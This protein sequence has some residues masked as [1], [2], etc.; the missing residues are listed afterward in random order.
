MEI[1]PIVASLKKHRIPTLLIV[2]QIALACA[3][4]CN[5]VFMIGG[6]VRQMR[7]ANAI[8]E[9][10]LVSV[11]LQGTD[12]K[13]IASDT[14]RNLAALRSIAGVQAV[15][16]VHTLPLTN[17]NWGWSFGITPD[18]SVTDQKN[19]N[20]TL[21]FVGQGSQRALGLRLLEGRYFSD[22]EYVDNAIAGGALPNT[23]LVVITQALGKQLWPGQSALGKTLYSKPNYYTVV[24]VVADVLRPRL[25]SDNRKSYYS[26]FFPV[27]ADDV[28]R[29]YVLRGAPADRDRILREAIDALQ[30]ANPQAVVKGVTFQAIRDKYYADT[31]SMVWILVLV[32]AVMLAVT[33]F[34][35]V[36]LTSFWV[37]Q[38]RRQI[39]IRRAVG[40]TR[41][42]ILRYFRTEN[43]LL[44]SAGVVL[45]MIMA[46]GVNL[47]LMKQ[48]ELERMPWY[49]LPAGALALWLIG[50]LAVS[51]PA[52]RA[53]AVPP[54][55]ATQPA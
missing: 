54:V 45:G 20:V 33:A 31:N 41:A 12:P 14:Q 35:I 23:H 44:S 42:D 5:A 32:C 22:S 26:A 2:L 8:D 3:V 55:V 53:A 16:V 21:Y 18:S 10:G 15:S 4:L 27:G 34:G 36:G 43:F 9:Q 51:G 28:L 24:G 7:L 39:G 17:N 1:R 40:A 38:R 49:Y 6:R 11:S 50:Q 46:Y 29:T 47:Y 25:W 52:M 48:Y 37:G 30:T 13:L 19:T